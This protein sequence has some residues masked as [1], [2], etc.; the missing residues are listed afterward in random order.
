MNQIE[1]DR[2]LILDLKRLEWDLKK[3][4]LIPTIDEAIKLIARKYADEQT[5]K[6]SLESL[7]DDDSDTETEPFDQNEEDS[8]EL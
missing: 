5:D 3:E 6:E 2:Q 1:K 7:M 8:L 4:G